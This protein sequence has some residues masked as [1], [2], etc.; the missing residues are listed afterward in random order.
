MSQLES[1]FKNL[2]AAARDMRH[3][4]TRL[5]S[6][7]IKAM[8]LLF[9]AVRAADLITKYCDCC[10]NEAEEYGFPGAIDYLCQ[11]CLHG[12]RE[13]EERTL[14]GMGDS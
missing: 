1:E 8:K 2:L 7:D 6:R 12:R 13:H 14:D 9:D 4:S 10:G 5:N 11:P 3:M